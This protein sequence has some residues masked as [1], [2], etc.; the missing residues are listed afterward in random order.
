MVTIKYKNGKTINFETDGFKQPE[1]CL[2]RACYVD[3]IEEVRYLLNKYP[4]VDVDA[5]VISSNIRGN[6]TPLIL[7]GKADIV[8]MLIDKGAD[9]NRV[10]NTGNSKI[11]ALDSAY[12]DLGN[13][14]KAIHDDITALIALLKKNNAKKFDELGDLK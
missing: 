3:N 13:E 14:D 9:V 4:E 7:T 6:G 2:V 5:I 12:K 11:T 8:Q 1:F 10:Y